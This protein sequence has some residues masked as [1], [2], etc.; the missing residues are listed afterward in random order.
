MVSDPSCGQRNEDRVEHA[1]S[2]VL[3][4]A[5][6]VHGPCLDSCSTRS[7]TLF[8]RG[9]GESSPYLVPIWSPSTVPVV[10]GAR[11]VLPWG[12]L[13]GCGSRLLDVGDD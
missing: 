8:R 3:V 1:C 9:A 6:R 2:T 13:P 7:G 4:N 11:S 5:T 10:G 12:E